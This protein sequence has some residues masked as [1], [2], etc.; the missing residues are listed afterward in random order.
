PDPRPLAGR[1]MS[2]GVIA[3]CITLHA[4][5]LSTSSEYPDGADIARAM[6]VKC[7]LI[8]PLLRE[9]RAIGTISLRRREAQRFTNHQIQ[10]LEAFAAQAVIAIENVRLFDE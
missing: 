1:A 3:E 6:G 7:F 10:L 2:A 4:P 5:D 9:G 8:A